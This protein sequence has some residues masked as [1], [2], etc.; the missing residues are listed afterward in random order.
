MIT[1]L[2]LMPRFHFVKLRLHD[3]QDHLRDVQELVCDLNVTLLPSELRRGY[4]SELLIRSHTWHKEMSS[5]SDGLPCVSEVL[6]HFRCV[7]VLS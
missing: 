3:V 4:D 1:T 7:K 2:M 6:A 5:A